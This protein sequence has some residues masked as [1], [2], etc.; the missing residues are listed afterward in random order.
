MRMSTNATEYGLDSRSDASSLSRPSWPC[1][2]ESVTVL[3][4]GKAVREDAREVL[5]RD[6]HAV[7]DHLEPQAPL[8][9]RLDEGGCERHHARPRRPGFDG[10]LGVTDQVD[11]DLDH[12]VFIERE[13]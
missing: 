3:L 4:C 1:S 9:I 11:Q 8:A 5:D 7:V 13:A 10:V 12:L 6:A 2:A